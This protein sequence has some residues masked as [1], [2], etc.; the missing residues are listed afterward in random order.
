M[1]Q[2]FKFV[3]N[4]QEIVLRSFFYIVMNDVIC[5]ILANAILVLGNIILISVLQSHFI[6]KSMYPLN[7]R[8][9]YVISRLFLIPDTYFVQYM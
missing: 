4:V 8:K 7:Y 1:I 5:D 9:M 2:H 3:E 6:A